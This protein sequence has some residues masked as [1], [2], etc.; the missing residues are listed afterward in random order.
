MENLS[1]YIAR[2]HNTRFTFSRLHADWLQQK[3]NEEM[4]ELTNEQQ[5]DNE[6][7]K[8]LAANGGSSPR[9]LIYRVENRLNARINELEQGLSTQEAK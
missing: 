6:F 3:R 8:Q 7:L 5:L 2:N 1:T 4:N 9:D